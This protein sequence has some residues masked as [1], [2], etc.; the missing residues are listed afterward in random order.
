MRA[1]AKHFL[2][3]YEPTTFV[4]G[5]SYEVPSK[6]WIVYTYEVAPPRTA[7]ALRLL[8]GAT[9]PSIHG[10]R[11]IAA[12]ETYAVGDETKTSKVGFAV[13]S[14]TPHQETEDLMAKGIEL[15]TS[16]ADIEVK[17]SGASKTL[18]AP[19]VALPP[20]KEHAYMV[21]KNDGSGAGAAD[22]VFEGHTIKPGEELHFPMRPI[23]PGWTGRLND[24]VAKPHIEFHRETITRVDEDGTRE[25]LWPLKR[26]D[27]IGRY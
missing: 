1:F 5:G 20:A 16:D 18:R 11:A 15:L 7:S 8:K 9:F 27:K 22:I 23:T 21:I 6:G 19:M 17:V 2:D 25:Q 14:K 4:L 3:D 10:E 24:L 12:V 26:I 13:E